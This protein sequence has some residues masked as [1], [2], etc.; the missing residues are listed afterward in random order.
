MVTKSSPKA[1]KTTSA[2]DANQS[3]G[4]SLAKVKVNLPANI[5][6]QFANEVAALQKRI[7]APSGDRITVTQG[8]TMKLPNGL[9]VDEIECVV[10]DFVAANFYYAS[11][12]D[13]QNIVPPDCFAIGMEPAGLTPSD[14]SPDKQCAACAGCWANQFK[15][16]KNGRGK[17]CSNTRLLAV[18]PLD[19][20]ADSN[21]MILKVSSTGLKSFDGHVA[22]VAAKY[23]V[24]IRGVTTRVTMSDE[25]YA[26]LRF[27]VIEKLSPKDPLLAIAQSLKESALVRLQTEPDVTAATAAPA[28]ARRAPAKKAP[29]RR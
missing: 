28:P 19:A 8:R 11:D 14:N 21:I 9:E 12:F 10:V 5:Q 25:E 15:S 18:I 3:A 22:N 23:G 4:T 7:A 17:A 29:A 1:T 26:S 27:A 24:P 13:R 6:E 2:F 20:D 16:A